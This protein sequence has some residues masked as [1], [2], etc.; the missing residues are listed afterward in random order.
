MAAATIPSTD[1]T[2]EAFEAVLYKLL[3]MSYWSSKSMSKLGFVTTRTPR[4]E[5]NT[6]HTKGANPPSN[7][8]LHSS[9]ACKKHRTSDFDASKPSEP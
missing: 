1:R 3:S 4:K 6:S 9:K 8:W 2:V 7:S 5:L